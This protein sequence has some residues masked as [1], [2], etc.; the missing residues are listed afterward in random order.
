MIFYSE[1]KLQNAHKYFLSVLS[2]SYLFLHM[3]CYCLNEIVATYEHVEI[4]AIHEWF[5]DPMHI[6]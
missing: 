1:N 6:I 4:W 2:M 3:A 5:Y